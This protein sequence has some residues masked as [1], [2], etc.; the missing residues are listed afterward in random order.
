MRVYV[1]VQKRIN[2]ARGYKFELDQGRYASRFI[3]RKGKEEIIIWSRD[4]DKA[5]LMI[6]HTWFSEVGFQD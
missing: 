5:G 1:C 3:K 2:K 6:E 4:T